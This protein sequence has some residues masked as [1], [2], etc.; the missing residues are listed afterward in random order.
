MQ[1]KEEEEREREKEKLYER[2]ERR[3][4]LVVEHVD[5]NRRP[6][7]YTSHYNSTQNSFINDDSR[8]RQKKKYY[9][10]ALSP[11]SKSSASDIDSTIDQFVDKIDDYKKW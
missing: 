1:Q 8:Y 9:S 11:K 10:E 5:I 3:R 6:S 4:N 7:G 2:L